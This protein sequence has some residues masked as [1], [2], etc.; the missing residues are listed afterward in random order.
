M[1]ILNRLFGKKQGTT[2]A[3][4]NE[5]MPQASV[6]IPDTSNEGEYVR[7][8]LIAEFK[9]E[10]EIRTFRTDPAFAE[11]LTPLNAKQ[12]SKAIKE[13]QAILPRFPDFDLI[14][15][16]I[17]SAYRYSQQLTKSRDILSEGIGKAKRKS[18]LLT[19]MGET[20]WQL[21][22]LN[23]AVYW[24]S[25]ALHC[26]S[27]NPIDH[28]AYLLMS[29]VAEGIGLADFGQK[30]LSRV[31]SLKAGQIR[32]E[33]TSAESLLRLVKNNKTDAIQK[34]LKDLQSKY[35]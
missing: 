20:E 17:G 10:Q 1:S 34:T 9:E 6:N 26:L 7:R 31:D 19:D 14:Y 33:R 18:L 16:W 35:F 24:W 30:L 32:L 28:N 29:Y 15:K 4:S 23:E 3:S 11:I 22:N 8:C 27:A 5:L 25:Q 2:A 12:Y 13:G 21:G